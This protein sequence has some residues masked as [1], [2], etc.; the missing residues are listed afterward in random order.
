MACDITLGY[1]LSGH[2]ESLAATMSNSP[3]GAHSL[4]RAD[5]CQNRNRTI[6]APRERGRG[7]GCIYQHGCSRQF[8]LPSPRPQ[9]SREN[10]ASGIDALPPSTAGRCRICGGIP[11]TRATRARTRERGLSASGLSGML[12]PFSDSS[13]PFPELRILGISLN[14]FQRG[15]E[16]KHVAVPSNLLSLEQLSISADQ[17]DEAAIVELSRLPR[18]REISISPHFDRNGA[19]QLK[20]RLEIALPNCKVYI[21]P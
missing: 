2:Q 11:T 1:V 17:I 9:S 19:A 12:R 10:R 18:L 15:D 7:V 20:R 5:G 6:T 3:D 21:P 8:L 16:F 4:Q 14:E 13:T